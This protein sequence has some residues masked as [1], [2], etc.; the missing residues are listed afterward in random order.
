M[1]RDPAAINQF[2]R[3]GGFWLTLLLRR[4]LPYFAPSST[5]PFAAILHIDDGREIG[6]VGASAGS[7]AA[8]RIVYL[9]M[10]RPDGKPRSRDVLLEWARAPG[11][12]RRAAEF[13]ELARHASL[14][15]VRTCYVKIAEHYR[16]LAEVGRS[17]YKSKRTKR[18]WIRRASN[19][20]RQPL[21]RHRRPCSSAFRSFIR[22]TKYLA[23]LPYRDQ[24]STRNRLGK[25]VTTRHRDA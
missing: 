9:T 15:A 19:N 5:M 21:Q 8:F 7:T 20:S 14:P 11:S 25:R 4:P 22:R 2:H 23:A 6:E 16:T 13:L 1:P 17:G 10:D 24:R 18:R 12:S 3:V